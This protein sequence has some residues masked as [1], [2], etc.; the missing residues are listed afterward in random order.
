MIFYCLTCS[1]QKTQSELSIIPIQIILQKKIFSSR[2]ISSDVHV[3]NVSWGLC[4]QLLAHVVIFVVL[5]KFEYLNSLGL[6]I[7]LQLHVGL[8]ETVCLTYLVLINIISDNSMET[9]AS[10]VLSTTTLIKLRL[11]CFAFRMQAYNKFRLSLYKKCVPSE[12]VLSVIIC[13]KNNNVI[14]ACMPTDFK[15]QIYN[16]QYRP[17]KSQD[18]CRLDV[19]HYAVHRAVDKHIDLQLHKYWGLF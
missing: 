1:Y 12:F 13:I 9:S 4:L 14:Q 3:F 6:R 2:W 10:R 17:W 19:G 8:F 5:I 16:I 18:V 15:F 7:T 11:N